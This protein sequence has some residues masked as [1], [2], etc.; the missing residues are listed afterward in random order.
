MKKITY[1]AYSVLALVI[2]GII[3]FFSIKEP[4]LISD[5]NQTTTVE[6]TT[7]REITTTEVEKTTKKKEE[8]S[9]T[10]SKP[11]NYTQSDLYLLA[12]ILYAEAGGCGESEMAKVGQV[13]LNRMNTNYWEFA[14]CNTIYEVLCQENGYP[15]TLRKI[16]NGIKPS[17]LALQVAEGLLSGILDSGL[18]DNVF[19][20]TKEIPSWDASVVEHTGWHYYSVPA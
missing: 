17:K 18:D 12:Q 7:V 14:H 5:I 11:V 16:N 1:I 6:S 10:K 8:T 2:V 20:Q 15:T 13:V 3:C 19:W 9:T 4:I